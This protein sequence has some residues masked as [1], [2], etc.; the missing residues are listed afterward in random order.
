MSS[1]TNIAAAIADAA[2]TGCDCILSEDI[3]EEVP[4]GV[5]SSNVASHSGIQSPPQLKSAPSGNKPQPNFSQVTTS[6]CPS[7]VVSPSGLFCSLHW[8]ESLY[9]VIFRVKSHNS[10]DLNDFR[11]HEID[12]GQCYSIAW[13]SSNTAN[14]EPNSSIVEEDMFA[15][16]T[17]YK[18]ID[19]GKK[20]KT[21]GL[22]SSEKETKRGMFDGCL[23]SMLVI[24]R[25][26]HDNTIT[27]II[28]PG[29]PSDV[30]EVL[31]NGLLLC[32]TSPCKNTNGKSDMKAV[33]QIEMEAI[34][35]QQNAEEKSNSV[36]VEK[37][38][39]PQ[40]VT[41]KS[42]FYFIEISSQASEQA[43][44]EPS[45]PSKTTHQTIKTVLKLVAIGPTMPRVS[46]ISWDTP[47]SS[48]SGKPSLMQ[49][50]S[51]LIDSKISIMCLSSEQLEGGAFETSLHTVAIVDPSPM[52][53]LGC[54]SMKWWNGVL[55]CATPTDMY[56]VFVPTPALANTDSG[57]GK[58]KIKK[59]G[60]NI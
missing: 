16:I 17:P 39:I 40:L 46:S 15:V 48:T 13:V 59:L 10:A 41:Y 60:K 34:L 42:Q 5:E 56:A 12:R 58:N 22:F 8:P 33:S 43:T 49:L 55:F 50:F 38:E 21:G 44:T 37:V 4:I 23:P 54:T 30:E 47:Y 25:I 28:N 52:P 20:K 53:C 18:R 9:Y 11:M 6:S 32:I 1:G 57:K 24:K 19:G 3:V 2:M 45:T 14:L 31:S 26:S 27:E 36:V 7:L 29:G 51:V 35:A